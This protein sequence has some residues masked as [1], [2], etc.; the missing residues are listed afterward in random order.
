[1]NTVVA[2]GHRLE[3]AWHGPGPKEAPTLVFL[4]EGL[5]SVSAWKDFPA[6][7]AA[8][9]RCGALVYSRWGYGGS[10]PGTLPRPITYMHD[11]AR[12]TLP[13]L[14]RVLG[15]R[16]SILVGHSDGASIAILYA[17]GS[18][19]RGLDGL[20]L[21]A[22]H[23][24]VEDVSVQ[25]IARAAEAYRTTD[26]H[27]RLE[28]HHG[29]NT[30]GAFRGWN[31][32]WLHPDFRAWNI[33]AFLPAIQVPSLVLQG[34]DD[35]YGTVRQVDAIR[36]QSGGRVEVKILRQCGHAPHRDQPDLTRESIV[37]FVEN[38]RGK[39]AGGGGSPSGAAAPTMGTM[40]SG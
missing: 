37:G 7:V 3:Y 17:G 19:A 10:D 34:E 36:T 5:G 2:G 20:V 8:E 26:L 27:T 15:L 18:D 11:E 30:E 28:R 12:V 35:A 25:S 23:V 16:R 21:E 1:M 13:D 32:V 40:F 39:P 14:V 22:P 9:A 4:H 33:E 6:Q 29:P 31:D 24:F 38:V